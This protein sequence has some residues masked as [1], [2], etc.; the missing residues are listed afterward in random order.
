MSIPSKTQPQL[1]ALGFPR[2]GIELHDGSKLFG[3]VSKF[4][5]YNVYLKD[6]YGDVLDVPHRII[7]RALLCIDGGKSDDVR[8]A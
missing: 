2:I 7:K 5:K 3:K 6:E 1:R 8:S 4:T